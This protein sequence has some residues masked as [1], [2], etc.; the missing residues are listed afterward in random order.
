M[1][2][3]R[4]ETENA[5]CQF[6]LLKITESLEYYAFEENVGEALSLLNF[7][8]SSAGDALSIPQGSDYFACIASDLIRENHGVV[9]CK[10]CNKNYPSG[11]LKVAHVSSGK[12]RI[13]IGGIVKEAIRKSPQRRYRFGKFGGHV[14]TCPKGHEL[15]PVRT[16]KT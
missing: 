7:L 9:T 5:V 1:A 11:R 8:S 12:K 14:F 6:N 3:V 15:F 10:A 13:S 4:F 2:T 16:W